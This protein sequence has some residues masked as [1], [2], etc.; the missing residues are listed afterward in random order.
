MTTDNHIE[1]ITVSSK[2]VPLSGET[3]SQHRHR[4]NTVQIRGAS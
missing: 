1:L 2:N 3:H 4:S